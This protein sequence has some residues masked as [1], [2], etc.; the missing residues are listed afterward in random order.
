MPV[1]ELASDHYRVVLFLKSSPAFSSSAL[2]AAGTGVL[3]FGRVLAA[4]SNALFSRRDISSIRA[5]FA[6]ENPD[7]FIGEPFELAFSGDLFTDDAPKLLF[8]I[9]KPHGRRL[10]SFRAPDVVG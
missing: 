9:G 7:D 4:L 3:R 2:R 8:C 5:L 1:D 10:S 6:G